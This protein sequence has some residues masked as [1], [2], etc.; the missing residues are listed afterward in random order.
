M[1]QSQITPNI[2]II[3]LTMIY[4]SKNSFLFKDISS[5]L[6][7]WGG[8]NLTSTIFIPGVENGNLKLFGNNAFN[9]SLKPNPIKLFGIADVLN[10]FYLRS[11]YE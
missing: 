6:S 7:N 10:P 3:K 4:L 5:L 2:G 11:F 8:K 9:K 1:K